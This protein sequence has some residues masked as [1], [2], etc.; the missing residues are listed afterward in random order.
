MSSNEKLD[1][2]KAGV[3]IKAADQAISLITPLVKATRRPGVLSDL[4]GFAGFFRIDT[5]RYPKPVLVSGTDG[6]G[7]KLRVA[8][9]AG[10]HDTVG[11][12]LVAMCVNDILVHGA[13]PLFFLDYLATGKVIPER[14]E[15]IVRGIAEG[16][17]QAGM[18]L[19][20]G[21]TAEMPGFYQDDEYDLA[22]FAVGVANEDQII[23]GER[24]E[25]GNVVIG[26]AS[27]GLHSNGYSLARKVLFDTA[28]FNYDSYIDEL[29]WTVAE[30]LLTP[31]RIYVKSIM[32]LHNAVDVKGLAHIT[33]GGIIENFKRVIPA[34][35]EACIDSKAWTPAPIFHLL[36]RLGNVEPKEMFR[37]F[38]MGIGFIV[39]V[40]QSQAEMTVAKLQELGEKPFI[41]GEI[42]SGNNEVVIY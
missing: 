26:L 9:M 1:Y 18:A 16:C 19:I 4:G 6:V 2:R 14:I 25:A 21:E 37:T 8:H 29:G 27:S 11:I 12:D 7:T 15:E 36:Q 39:V 35:L 23:T 24:I 33:G 10:I 34:G 22:G 5:E 30:E 41:I 3:D 28:G 42:L 17:K 13:E 38:N 20:G 40:D 32:E 31:T